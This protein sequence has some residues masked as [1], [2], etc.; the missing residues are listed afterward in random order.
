MQFLPSNLIVEWLDVVPGLQLITSERKKI[1]YCLRLICIPHFFAFMWKDS[2]P[3]GQNCSLNEREVNLPVTEN[4][5]SVFN[6]NIRD[7]YQLPCRQTHKSN[8]TSL[9]LVSAKC[10]GSK[11]STATMTS[12]R[13]PASQINL[14]NSRWSRRS[15]FV[16]IGELPLLWSCLG[17]SLLFTSSH[18]PHCGN[19]EHNDNLLLSLEVKTLPP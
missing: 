9:N 18:L 16:H 19:T 15:Q 5:T 7:E 17:L 13:S 14:P 10:S 4:L 11:T 3:W 2:F 6:L 8:E 1:T 12:D